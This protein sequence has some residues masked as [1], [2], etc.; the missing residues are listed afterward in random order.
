LLGRIN[1]GDAD[2][3]LC[4]MQKTVDRYMLLRV[5]TILIRHI[6]YIHYNPVK[7]GLVKNVVDWR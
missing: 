7:H 6:D 3:P 4:L 1:K 2:P 5:K